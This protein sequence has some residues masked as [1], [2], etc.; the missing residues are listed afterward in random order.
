MFSRY[1]ETIPLMPTI[2]SS[3]VKSTPLQMKMKHCFSSLPHP[4]REFGEFGFSSWLSS[5]LAGLLQSRLQSVRLIIVLICSLFAVFKLLMLFVFPHCCAMT[6]KMIL[7]IL[8]TSYFLRPWFL[9][10]PS[11]KPSL[12]EN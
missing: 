4:S 11:V 2:T 9:A 12:G 3:K 1:G 5:G 10:L 7:A 8:L 6:L